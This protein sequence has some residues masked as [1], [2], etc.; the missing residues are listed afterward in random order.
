MQRTVP[1]IALALAILFATWVLFQFL[2]ATPFRDNFI[3]DFSAT[4]LGVVIGVPVAL[5]I[6]RSQIKQGE[7]TRQTEALKNRGEKASQYLKMLQ[8]SLNT[9][10]TFLDHVQARLTPGSV[11]YPSLDIEQLESTSALKYEILDDLS[12]CGMLDVAR[13]ELRF[14]SRLLDLNLTMSFGGFRAAVGE[15]IFRSE[16]AE[17]V[18][19][20][21]QQIPDAKK[22]LQLA[23]GKIA[24][25]LPP[26]SSGDIPAGSR[27]A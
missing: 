3:A 8:L 9:C 22:A 10:L 19:R 11:I 7:D 27:S 24:A 1:W 6:N 23:L 26:S 14:I 16:Q 4:L 13:Y 12:L 17:V 20:I 2:P 18:R 21:Q 5:A 25:N 15:A